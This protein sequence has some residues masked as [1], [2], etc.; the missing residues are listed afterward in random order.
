M[1]LLLK[2]CLKSCSWER[3][4]GQVD[5]GVPEAHMQFHEVLPW[6]TSEGKQVRN[7]EQLLDYPVEV[8]YQGS[9]GLE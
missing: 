8:T 1:E 6:S 4:V 3:A 5:R 9:F 2:A 7:C